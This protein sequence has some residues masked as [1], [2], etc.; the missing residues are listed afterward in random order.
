MQRT[1]AARCIA[2]C[3]TFAVGVVALN[4]CGKGTEQAKDATQSSQSQPVQPTIEPS[5]FDQARQAYEKNDLDSA[6]SILTELQIEDPNHAEG[7]LL[8]AR[9]LQKQG[10]PKLALQTTQTIETT[11]KNLTL[12]VESLSLELATQLDDAAAQEVS[13]RRL[14]GSS[15]NKKGYADGL[16]KL[17]HR[18]GR[19]FE[20][21]AIADFLCRRGEAS[22]DQ[23]TS[24]AFGDEGYPVDAKTL[25]DAKKHF[26]S[27]LGLAR[28]LLNNDRIEDA[29]TELAGATGGD[30]LE[31]HVSAF[32]GRVLAESQ[33]DQQFAGWHK[34]CPAEVKK[35][36][37]YWAAVGAFALHQR[38][39]RAAI[40]ALLKAAELNGMDPVHYR[41]LAQACEAIG[42]DQDARN[43]VQQA[44]RIQG[45]RNLINNSNL[46]TD[47]PAT[48]TVL[49]RLYLELGRP[50]ESLHWSQYAV[51]AN[52]VQQ[53]AAI[54]TRRNQMNA[55]PEI[56][57]MV[58]AAA[59]LEFDPREYDLVDL[60]SLITK[61]I[62]TNSSSLNQIP[63]PLNH[64]ASNVVIRL[65]NVAESVGLDFT[66]FHAS[67]PKPNELAFYETLGGG[68]GIV[69]FDL[70]GWPD[71][72][73]SQG[74]SSPE[75]G[76]SNLGEDDSKNLASSN[77]LFR[78]IG[79]RF[80]DA[81]LATETLETRYSHGI[82]V[83]DVNQDGFADIFVGNIGKNRLFINCGDGTFADRSDAL[84]ETDSFITSSVAIADIS[85]DS[86][87]DLFEV[88]YIQ[89]DGAFAPVEYDDEGYEIVKGPLSFQGQ[90]DRWF[91]NN[92]DGTF[93][94]RTIGSEIAESGTG[95]GLMITDLFG[96]GQNSIFVGNDARPNHLLTPSD[97]GLKNV[98]HVQGVAHGY[99]GSSV[100]CMGIAAGDFDR[101]GRVDLHVTNF[102]NEFDNL[103]L[104][105]E[106]GIFRDAAVGFGI[107][108]V[109]KSL[110]GFGTKAIDI[111]RD[112]WLDLLVTNGHI[113]DQRHKNL[114]FQMPPTLH[115]NQQ[116]LFS[117]MTVDDP[118][119]YWQGKYLGRSIASVD[120]DRNG[121][122]DFVVTHLDRPT[123]LLANQTDTP[124]KHIQ[125]ELVGTK[126]E[127]DAIGAV[128]VAKLTN[129]EIRQWNTAGDGFQCSDEAII[130][131]GLGVSNS[132]DR[133]EVRW[134][135]GKSKEYSSIQSGGQ[136]LLIEGQDL[137]Y[138]R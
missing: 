60:N 93:T 83:G 108:K 38:A 107:D 88:N 8:L 37:D 36:D 109:S 125:I 72:Y 52:Q 114:P 105:D 91:A 92:A 129:G 84:A 41:R 135:S 50:F 5:L 35:F 70:D 101:D 24:L 23:L 96:N 26:D 102:L 97:N 94:S 128:V 31:P 25:D 90:A 14:L 106:S 112:G 11:S 134:P 3:F 127:R 86:L 58:R 44:K 115:S 10:K 122:T 133:V 68:A 67:E 22:L 95:L 59:L 138:R 120:F 123:A 42:R 61:H 99:F 4:G 126:S 119:G 30:R 19:V 39:Y 34:Q 6:A 85:G 65:T 2:C 40:A 80:V 118:S 117:P 64:D 62:D 27:G 82:A 17:F 46:K 56:S 7:S 100:A 77:R 21:A 116:T 104:Q 1:V 53:H 74:N 33:A 113:S 18:Q 51:P 103:F 32:L 47:L 71:M 136:Y 16:W 57:A 132:L 20:A 66:W 9:V 110:L 130:E 45:I 48:A 76:F 54:K 73:L 98:A 12:E 69:D 78:N 87:P 79:G 43:C 111:D 55:A 15:P 89:R 81:T 124:G 29:R 75:E 137:A 131:I 13:L 63:P 121:Q 28:W 49:A